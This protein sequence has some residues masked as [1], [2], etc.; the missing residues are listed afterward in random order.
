MADVPDDDCRSSVPSNAESLESV[1]AQ[2]A[3]SRVPP[4]RV[5]LRERALETRNSYQIGALPG[6]DVSTHGSKLFPGLA[7]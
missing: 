6:E 1:L 4:T 3:A 5:E 2:N 7:G